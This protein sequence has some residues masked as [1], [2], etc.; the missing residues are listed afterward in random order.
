MSVVSIPP[1]EFTV[2]QKRELVLEYAE[3]RYGDKQALLE[4]RGVPWHVFRRWRA[5]MADGDLASGKVPRQTGRMA[6]NDVAEIRRLEAENAKL[7]K[8]LER[9]EADRDRMEKAADALGKA[10]DV[11]R[12]RGVASDK[13][14]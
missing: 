2:E 10:I 9:A 13:D 1:Q 5:A 12:E 4:E 6:E 3:T 7:Q 8:R 11:M 14:A